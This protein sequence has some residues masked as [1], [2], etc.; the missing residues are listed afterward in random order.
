MTR[1]AYADTLSNYSKGTLQYTQPK[2]KEWEDGNCIYSVNKPYHKELNVGAFSVTQVCA[3]VETR[4]S[5]SELYHTQ[6]PTTNW[7]RQAEHGLLV[8]TCVN[9]QVKVTVHVCMTIEK[10]FK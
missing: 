7:Y 5:T 9:T 4:T 8:V 2:V 3:C 1:C 10:L 6:K